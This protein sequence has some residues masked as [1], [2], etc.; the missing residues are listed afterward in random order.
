LRI[1]GED[2]IVG[3]LWLDR[4]VP[5]LGWVAQET[6]LVH[7]RDASA[8]PGAD[9]QVSIR[10]DDPTRWTWEIMEIPGRRPVTFVRVR[11]L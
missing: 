9:T 1:D 10:G 4:A 8:W 5:V 3:A 2:A 7:V 11:I 6:A